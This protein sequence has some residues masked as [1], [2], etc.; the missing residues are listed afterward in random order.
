MKVEWSEDPMNPYEDML[1]DVQ[2]GDYVYYYNHGI[3]K[4]F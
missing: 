1:L 3:F 4:G 2:H